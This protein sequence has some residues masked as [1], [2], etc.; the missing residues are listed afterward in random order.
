MQEGRAMIQGWRGSAVVKHPSRASILQIHPLGDGASWA[1]VAGEVGGPS[2][3]SRDDSERYSRA[4]GL[5]LQGRQE[6]LGGCCIV[7]LSLEDLAQPVP[8]L[9]GCR[10]H[11][12]C[13]P[14]DLLS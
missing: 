14:E 11:L 7:A 5:Q 10:V 1:R 12:H 2:E 4:A 13:I 6:A 8:D 9:M 3:H